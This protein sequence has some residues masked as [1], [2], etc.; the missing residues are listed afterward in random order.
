MA[1]FAVSLCREDPRDVS[2]AARRWAEDEP[3]WPSLAG[4]L[5]LVRKCREQR[6]P[7]PRLQAPVPDSRY[8]KPPTI[9]DSITMRR[10]I[11]ELRQHPEWV[12]SKALIAI[13]E[14]MLA[15]WEAARGQAA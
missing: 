9:R 14:D 3:R 10:N 8:D 2:E 7:K 15:R 13:G 1:V 11:A 5:S 6:I 12:G 4:L